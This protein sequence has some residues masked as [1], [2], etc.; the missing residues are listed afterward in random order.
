MSN[1]IAQLINERRK[2]KGF[3]GKAWD[4]A[5]AGA[6]GYLGYKALKNRTAI[7]DTLRGLKGKYVT[8]HQIKGAEAAAYD[9]DLEAKGIQG[10]ID[11]QIGDADT[12]EARAAVGD[13]EQNPNLDARSD[14]I[15]AKKEA[16]ERAKRQQDKQD[17]LR[18]STDI[19][20]FINELG[21]K[22][23]SGADKYLKKVVEDKLQ[24]KIAK[25]IK[26]QK[27]Y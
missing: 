5:K 12:P 3:L 9:A 17:S 27:L 8:P 19:K 2:R 25:Q 18:E 26:T 22:N 7:G 21:Q 23:Y 15:R 24:T 20:N 4:L 13:R 10:D 6:L 16:I 11:K 1:S 14:A